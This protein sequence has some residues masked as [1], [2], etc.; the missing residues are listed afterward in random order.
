MSGMGAKESITFEYEV[1]EQLFHGKLLPIQHDTHN[2]ANNHQFDIDFN[3][4]FDDFAPLKVLSF[5][6]KEKMGYESMF[7]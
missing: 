7:I 2:S 3:I 4:G 5:S 1:N 6:D